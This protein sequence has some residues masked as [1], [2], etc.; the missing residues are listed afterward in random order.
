MITD[1]FG[2]RHIT[3]VGFIFAMPFYVALRIVSPNYYSPELGA[4]DSINRKIA[5]C[6]L[7]VGIGLGLTL[8]VP[9][10]MVEITYIVESMEKKKEAGALGKRGSYA[11]A[12]SHIPCGVQEARNSFRAAEALMRS[13][14]FR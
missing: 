6:G 9:P 11:L 10:V 7:L 4:P 8:V 12:V 1:R 3:A 13:S 2:P 14:T 5:L